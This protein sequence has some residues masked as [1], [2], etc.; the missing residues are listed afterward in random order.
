MKILKQ[1]L[2]GAATAAVFVGCASSPQV[3]PVSGEPY[4]GEMGDP[5]FVDYKGKKYK[6]CCEGCEGDFLKSPDKFIT[7][8]NGEADVAKP[9]K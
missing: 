8:I 2:V 3:C 1:L 5:Y 7:I 4:G 9:E 6:L